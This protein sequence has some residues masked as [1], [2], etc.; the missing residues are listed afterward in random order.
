MQ[1]Y[2]ILDYHCV[3]KHQKK[4]TNTINN[5]NWYVLYTSPRAEKQVKDRIAQ[6]GI[7]CWLPLHRSRRV[8]SDRVKMVDVPLFN[9]Y[10]FVKCKEHELRPLLAIYG[11]ARIVYYDGKP[12]VVRQKEIDA[13]KEFLELAT[14]H[15]L[16]VGDEVEILTGALKS[17]SGKVRKI[18]KN[19]LVLFIEQLGAT[20]SVNLQEVAPVKRIK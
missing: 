17:I 15:T 12:A 8:W 3:R 1:Y 20:V 2:E 9:S 5:L 18:K 7:E 19:Y 10:I 14:N 4:M 16:I 13:I 11:V 6:T